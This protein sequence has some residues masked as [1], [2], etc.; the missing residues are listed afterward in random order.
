MRRSD[1]I[2]ETVKHTL[3]ESVLSSFGA[4]FQDPG[5]V[6]EHLRKLRWKKITTGTAPT[7]PITSP[8]AARVGAGVRTI[9]GALVKSVG[10]KTLE[11]MLSARNFGVGEG[12]GVALGK[13]TL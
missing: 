11:K 7:S 4:G 2:R 13:D 10:Q 9:G 1:Q 6:G 12:P 8:L 3:E 5:K